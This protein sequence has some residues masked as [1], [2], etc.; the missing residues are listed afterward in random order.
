MLIGD[1]N[2]EV[3]ITKKRIRNIY[4]RVEGNVLKVSCPYFVSKDEALRF[5]E[6]RKDWILKI[7]NKRLKDSMMNIGD[8]IY[9]L[10]EEYK[11]VTEYGNRSFRV[12]GDTI[13]IRN[14]KLDEDSIR[15]AFYE[16]NKK[17][18]LN[19]IFARED[20]YLA[21]L[22]DYGY[23]LEPI[24]QVKYLTSMW[25]VCYNKKNQI[26]IS[27]R[28]IHFDLNCLDA[29]LWHELLH[30]IMPNHSSRFYEILE[31]HMPEYK[32]IIKTLK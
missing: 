2:F 20:K 14:R 6:D 27:V 1:K 8:T 9:Y 19:E 15:T 7:D 30:F 5:I 22:R 26:N 29:I 21:I 17:L 25:G 31:A 23:Y 11:L 13:Y 12:D 24:Y 4:L 28:L 18:L 32:A 3:V 10:G 16:C